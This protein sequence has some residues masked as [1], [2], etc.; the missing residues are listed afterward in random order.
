MAIR[1]LR[2]VTFDFWGTL[3]DARA[4]YTERRVAFLARHLEN[5]STDEVMR[6]YREATAV[7]SHISRLG[8]SFPT[9]SLLSLTLDALGTALP[10]NDRKHVARYWEEVILEDPPAPLPGI[11]RTLAH[12]ADLGLSLGLISDT[13]VSPGRSLRRVLMGAGLLCHF[14][15]LTFSDEIGVTKRRPQPFRGTLAAMGAGPD[16][17]LHVGDLPETDI[18]GA[19][20]AGMR[21]A[22]F[23]QNSRR[24]DGV[25]QADL[26][27]ERWADL[28]TGIAP[29]L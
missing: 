22:L 21:A 2:A 13:G 11:E 26:V 19:H 1:P 8:L 4:D 23:L 17:A 20:A 29:W 5:A 12:L 28:S 18:A 3:V 24:L 10:P 7:A 25:S 9:A 27:L 6:G 15:H 14:R 16:E